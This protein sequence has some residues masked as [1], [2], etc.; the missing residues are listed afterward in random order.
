MP[1]LL[2]DIGGDGVDLAAGA[3][4]LGDDAFQPSCVNVDQHLPGP[5]LGQAHGDRSADAIGGA[6]DDCRLIGKTR[7]RR[8]LQAKVAG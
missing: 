8:Q 3:G 1:A 6:G 2:G 4:D 5:F 7:H